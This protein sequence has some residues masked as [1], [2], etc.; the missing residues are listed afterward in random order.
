MKTYR[1]LGIAILIVLILATTLVVSAFHEPLQPAMGKDTVAWQSTEVPVTADTDSSQ[2]GST[3]G[4]FIMEFVIV[5]II[6]V[7]LIFRKKKK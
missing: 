3:T 2:V 6:A 7:P 4:I 1:S 5:L